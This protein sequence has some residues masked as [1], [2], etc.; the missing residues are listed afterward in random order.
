[1]VEVQS[2]K[3]KIPSSKLKVPSSRF[4]VQGL[5]LFKMKISKMKQ[6][7]LALFIVIIGLHASAQLAPHKYLVKFTDRNNSPYSISNPSAFLSAKAI[8]RRTN[9]GISIKYNDLPV[10]PAYIDSVTSTGVTLLC[11]SKWFN[12]VTIYTTDSIA[13][14]KIKAFPFVL[15]VDSVTRVMPY[16]SKYIIPEKKMTFEMDLTS[17]ANHLLENPSTI[18]EMKINAN[19]YNYG[20]AANQITMINLDY[21]HNL[22]YS[23]Q[24]M[25]IAVLDAGF[26]N[27]DTIHE[28]DSL[29][30]NNQILGTKDFVSPGGNVFTQMEHGMEVLSVMGA[31][32]SGVI[33]GTAPRAKDWLLR[34]ED[35][36]SEN[37]IEEYNW[38]SAAEFADSVGADVINSSLGYTTF[39]KPWMGHTYADMNG[40]TCPASIA[41]TIAAEKG[42][43]VCNAAGNSAQSSWHYIGAPAD[44][45]SILTV[46][47][48][49]DIG[50]YS[51]GFSS[52]GPTSDGRIKP[53]VATQGEGTETVRTNGSVQPG[54]G[55]SFATPVL[56][57]ATACLWQANPGMTN[58][59]IIAAIKQSASQYSNPDNL[60]GWGIPN[61]AAANLILSGIKVHNLDDNSFTIF[62]NPINTYLYVIFY[63]NDTE[64]VDI[65]IFD[66]AGKKVYSKPKLHKNAGCNYF[67]IN[68]IS[69]LSKGVYL[70]RITTGGKSYTRKMM[71]VE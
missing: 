67:A 4:K 52:T 24:G 6:N 66:I 38:A 21:L 5:G 27:A 29:W 61:F 41:A 40:R 37:I 36:S 62:P 18:N 56:T 45:D 10:N 63:S 26:N 71:K 49:N 43:I 16:E 7:I 57:G 44:A 47:S 3:L 58:Q 31:N 60:E 25:T 33:I 68:D 14:A 69:A 13:F 50:N 11:T 53:T 59:Q 64:Y 70:L 9:Q 55:T 34:S 23:G 1:M 28:F 65:D 22:G 35:A 39:D 20:L 46:G 15:N 2:P 32:T 48:V 19:T 8:V 54:N 42:M 30:I 17:N 12:S 51:A